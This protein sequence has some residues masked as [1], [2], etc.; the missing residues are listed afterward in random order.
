MI[1]KMLTYY[2]V[3][4]G[5]VRALRKVWEEIQRPQKQMM[6]GNELRTLTVWYRDG[7]VYH[8]ETP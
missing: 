8:E 5:T 2:A 6:V 3:C 1:N 7:T 4:L